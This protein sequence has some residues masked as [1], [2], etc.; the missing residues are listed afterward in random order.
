MPYLVSDR[1][2]RNIPIINP[3]TEEDN[4]R[5]DS[6]YCIE[7]YAMKYERYPL[8]EGS[9]GVKIYEEFKPGCFD[10]CDMRDII[11][12]YDHTGKVLARTRN[13]TLIVEAD[14]VGLRIT[15]DLSKSEQA[16]N[17]YEEISN[18]LVDRMSWGFLPGENYYDPE[19]ST[20]VHTKIKKIFDVSAVSIPANDDTDI[21]VRSIGDGEIVKKLQEM[22]NRRKR[23]E[24]MLKMGGIR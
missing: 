11:L 21:H 20:V 9:D 2:Y 13:G 4:K 5:I 18:R 17:L 12:Q 24:I 23:I 6:A 10:G 1:E 15:G 7:G 14:D 19:I 8:Y 16:R 3:I 22:Q